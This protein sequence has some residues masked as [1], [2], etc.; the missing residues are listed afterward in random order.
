M[1]RSSSMRRMVGSASASSGRLMDSSSGD[2]LA[3]QQM[4]RG[5]RGGL[6]V[7]RGIGMA[8]AGQEGRAGDV[9]GEGGS[10]T[11]SARDAN[12][13]AVGVGYRAHDPQAPPEAPHVTH[14]E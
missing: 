7:R 1:S 12:L 4:G 13:T 6:A 8:A 10:L 9:E 2:G 5:G 11:R 14:P 3:L